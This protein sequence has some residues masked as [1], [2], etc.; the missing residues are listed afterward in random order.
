MHNF[1]GD[2]SWKAHRQRDAS[3]YGCRRYWLR[4]VLKLRASLAP[5]GTNRLAVAWLAVWSAAKQTD[6]SVQPDV[7]TGSQEHPV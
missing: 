2:T 6:R 3:Q 7:T 5:S 4:T 1:A